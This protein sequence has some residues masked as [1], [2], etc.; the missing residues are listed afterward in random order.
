MT[1]T[2]YICR[3]QSKH[4]Q[5]LFKQKLYEGIFVHRKYKTFPVKKRFVLYD[6]LLRWL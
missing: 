3:L 5:L 6:D 1:F 2:K 4:L